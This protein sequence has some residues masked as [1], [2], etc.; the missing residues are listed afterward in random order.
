MEPLQFLLGIVT[1][2]FAVRLKKPIRKAAVITTTQVLGIVDKL[3]TTAYS[4]KEEIE[5]IVA[6]AHYENIK[7]NVGVTGESVEKTDSIKQNED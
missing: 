3:K 2:S 4:L 6:E 5:D 1:F 7:K